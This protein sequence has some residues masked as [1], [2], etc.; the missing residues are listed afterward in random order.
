MNKGI[1]NMGALAEA[2][3]RVLKCPWKKQTELK[4]DSKSGPL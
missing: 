1:T 4:R 3:G 2:G